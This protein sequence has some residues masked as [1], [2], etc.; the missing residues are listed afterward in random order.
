MNIINIIN[1]IVLI[2]GLPV[3]LKAFLYIG[4][5]LQTLDTLEDRVEKLDNTLNN[6]VLPQL[7]DIKEKVV[8]LETKVDVM[9]VWFSKHIILES[10]SK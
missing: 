5:K 7:R 9:W 1:A 8:A 10:Q 2:V 6:L 4:K 3:L